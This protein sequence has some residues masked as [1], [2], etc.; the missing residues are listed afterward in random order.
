MVGMF[1]EDHGKSP[2]PLGLIVPHTHEILSLM[3]KIAMATPDAAQRLKF[4]LGLMTVGKKR[5][6][7]PEHKN[8]KLYF[9]DNVMDHKIPNGWLMVMLAAFRANVSWDLKSGVFGWH[10]PIDELLPEVIDD[11][12]RVC[13]QEYSVN[14][15]KPDEMARN[16]SIYEQCYDKVALTL[17]RRN[18]A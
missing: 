4:K 7:S 15:I 6:G 1:E 18:V 11:L 14:R 10:V 3:D 8:T 12:V 16:A 17:H 13:V 5:S 9:I 2:S